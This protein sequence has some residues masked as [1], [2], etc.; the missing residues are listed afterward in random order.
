[1]ERSIRGSRQLLLKRRAFDAKRG[2]N[3]AANSRGTVI[4]VL[5]PTATNDASTLERARE[6]MRLLR[7]TLPG[8]Y[9]Q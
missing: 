7:A 9:R 6:E 5:A 1:M 2:E 3:V 4:L 8:I